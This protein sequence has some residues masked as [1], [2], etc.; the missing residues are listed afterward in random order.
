MTS[1]QF[2]TIKEKGNFLKVLSE[3]AHK[4]AK[5]LAFSKRSSLLITMNHCY[6]VQAYLTEEDITLLKPTSTNVPKEFEA[7]SLS[8]TPT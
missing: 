7:L 5:Y 8:V 1:F 4:E 2:R 3:E 6:K